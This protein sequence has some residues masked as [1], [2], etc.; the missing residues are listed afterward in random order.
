[1]IFE[2]NYVVVIGALGDCL[3]KILRPFFSQLEAKP[4]SI[5]PCTRDFSWL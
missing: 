3:K 4:E 5:T 2:S 1:M